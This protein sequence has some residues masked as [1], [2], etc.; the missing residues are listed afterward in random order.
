MSTLGGGG[1]TPGGVPGAWFN[2]VI[3]A[4]IIVGGPIAALSRGVTVVTV[5]VAIAIVGVGI[6]ME[7]RFV[8]VLR[9]Q[10][11]KARRDRE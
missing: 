6:L 10:Q 7:R 8:G 3:C 2:V 11:A 5:L 1:R 9:Q 4:I